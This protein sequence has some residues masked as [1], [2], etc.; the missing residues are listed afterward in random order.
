MNAGEVLANTSGDDDRR[1]LSAGE[2]DDESYLTLMDDAMINAGVRWLKQSGVISNVY[3][4]IFACTVSRTESTRQ[5]TQPLSTYTRW[6][7]MG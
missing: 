1:H 6:L 4:S 7:K 5:E 2:R 3:G